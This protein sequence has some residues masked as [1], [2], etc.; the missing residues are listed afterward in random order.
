MVVKFG[1]LNVSADDGD[2]LVQV[3]I[4]PTGGIDPVATI[5]CGQWLER[6]MIRLGYI[7]SLR[8]RNP[9]ASPCS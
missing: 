6:N 2:V 4:D 7:V 5:F 9:V 1:D 3:G 8:S